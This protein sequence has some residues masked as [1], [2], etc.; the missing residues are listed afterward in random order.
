MVQTHQHFDS[1]QVIFNEGAGSSYVAVIQSGAIKRMRGDRIVGL[2]LPGD[3]IGLSCLYS[4][5]QVDTAIALERS[6]VCRLDSKTAL[7][8]NP[9]SAKLLA[10][11][12]EQQ[13]WHLALQNQ[14]AMQRV[15]S[16]LVQLSK[17]HQARGLSATHIRLPLNR[18]DMANYLGLALETGSRL[19]SD[20]N[21]R[22]IVQIQARQLEILDLAALAQLEVEGQSEQVSQ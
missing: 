15:A 5:H 9:H 21:R 10:K 4:G 14:P 6:R 18:T 17:H 20:L 1:G 2:S 13:R 19:I 22:G 12:M 7:R 16:W 3:Y 11:E 8:Q